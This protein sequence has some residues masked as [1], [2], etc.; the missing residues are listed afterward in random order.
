MREEVSDVYFLLY[1]TIDLYR[2]Y[3]QGVDKD[4]SKEPKIMYGSLSFLRVGWQL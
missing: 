4:E 1:F 2:K 3:T